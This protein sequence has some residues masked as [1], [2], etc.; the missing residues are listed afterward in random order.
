M[1]NGVFRTL[2]EVIEFCD[3][4]GG[5][6]LGYDVP[7]QTL[8]ADSL[9]LTSNEKFQLISFLKTLTDTVNL[10]K[11]PSELP[12]FADEPKLNSRPIGGDY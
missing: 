1:H 9:H 4:G 8:A 11:K 2:E 7:F 3:N 12:T 6:S 5:V 10:T